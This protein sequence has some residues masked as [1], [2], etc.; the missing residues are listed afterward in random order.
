VVA[1]DYAFAAMG[2]LFLCCLPL[3]L[4]LRRGA[5]PDEPLTAAE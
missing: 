1:F 4:L 5:G 3:A 2:L